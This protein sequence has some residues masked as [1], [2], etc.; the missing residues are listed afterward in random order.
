MKKRDFIKLT[1]LGITGLLTKSSFAEDLLPNTQSGGLAFPGLRNHLSPLVESWSDSDTLVNHYLNHYEHNAKIIPNNYYGSEKISIKQF[2]HKKA[3]RNREQLIKAKDLYN[4]KLYFKTLVGNTGT[5]PDY[6]LELLINQN[7]GSLSALNKEIKRIAL[8]YKSDGWV[9]LVYNNESLHIITTEN[10]ANPL[11]ADQNITNEF[12][13][14]GI[15]LHQHAYS[16]G[17]F[18][19]KSHY[20]DWYLKHTNWNFV[21]HRY[22]KAN[23]G[24]KIRWI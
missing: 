7:F 18:K 6:L 14:I 3:Y 20:I 13:L 5:Q 24:N 9:W 11:F 19:D 22:K 15:D 16:G 8:S 4:H 2:I 23:T 17:K 1:A 12:P 10:Y 21:S